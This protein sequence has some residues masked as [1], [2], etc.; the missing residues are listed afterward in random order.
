MTD[1]SLRI[2]RMTSVLALALSA[3]ALSGCTGSATSYAAL[4]REA[5]SAD[6]VP[7]PVIEQDSGDAADLAS[8]R[9]VGEHS[10]SSLWLLRGVDQGTVC[11]LAYQDESAWGIGCGGEGGPVEMSGP[12]GH[13]ITVPDGYTTPDGATRISDNVYALSP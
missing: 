12:A 10:G 2:A 7:F 1:G 13:F 11:V 8:A 5:E 6:A 9:F 4:D 3:V